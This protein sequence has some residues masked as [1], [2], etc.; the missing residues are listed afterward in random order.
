MQITASKWAGAGILVMALALP[1][2]AEEGTKG[3]SHGH[4]HAHSHDHAGGDQTPEAKANAEAKAKISKGY[5]DDAQVADRTLSDWEGDWQSVYPLLQDGT[6]DPVWQHKAK[7]GDKSADAYR[8]YYE[9]GY[10]TDVTRIDIKGDQ[11][12]FYKGDRA[13]RGSYASD[14][15]EV[16]TYE[17]GNRGVRF[18]FRKTEGDAE[19][20]DFIQFSDHIIAPE[21]SSHF[22]LYWGS[23][24]KAL[25]SELTHWPTYYP[26]ALSADDVLH[27]MLHH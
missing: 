2:G 20:P 4:D 24:R 17:K 8:A 14:G 19:A 25:L 3:H 27:E 26:A 9:T 11:I 10:Q 13:A 22:H 5:F 21:K 23:D 15:Y 6:L 18:I 16:L 1:A 12:S 7:S